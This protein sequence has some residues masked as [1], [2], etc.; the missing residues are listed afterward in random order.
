[1]G[2]LPVIC[3][4]AFRTVPREQFIP[5]R[6][7]AQESDDDPYMPIDRERE[8]E[9]WYRLVNSDRVIVTQFDDGATHWP[10]T[11]YRPS[12]S[13]SMPSLVVGM[14][15]ELAPQPG[16][17]I[18][19]IG[20]G[21]GYNAALLAELVGPAG[22]V[23]SV[24]ID[25]DLAELARVRLV[26]AG[27]SNV[28]VVVA[29]GVAGV[30]PEQPWDRVIVTAGVHV[31]RLPYEW[32]D[33]S[34]ADGIV[35]TPM[36]TDLASGPLVRFVV[37]ADG[38]ATGRACAMRVGFMELRQQRVAAARASQ[39]RWDDDS[40]D[41]SI[42]TT[43]P[44]VALLDEAARWAIALAVPC[45][46]YNLEKPTIERRYGLAWLLDPVTG[47]WASAV[48]TDDEHRF[49]VRQRGPRKLWNEVETAYRWWQHHHQPTL[50]TWDWTVTP[51]EQSVT[52][53]EQ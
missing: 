11:G 35:L 43:N 20:T 23:T 42:T 45:C 12:C 19:E 15:A 38:T 10:E 3:A 36:R 52:L 39:L 44:F 33:H 26:Q 37:N 6:I 32:V 24:E 40:A 2:E 30:E 34:R 21:T 29:D 31:G 25:P 16:E 46:R 5:D 41:V 4:S 17:R 27:Y 22:Q 8:P 1:M 13:T 48:P 18:L 51:Y 28:R 53:A 14:L 47:S 50:E 49:I 7:W 9:H